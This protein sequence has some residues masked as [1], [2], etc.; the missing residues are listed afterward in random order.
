MERKRGRKGK[1]NN[2]K[3]KIN[4]SQLRPGFFPP[5]GDKSKN[6]SIGKGGETS[7]DIPKN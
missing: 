3:N 5:V 7:K 2:D 1:S 4:T 6:S